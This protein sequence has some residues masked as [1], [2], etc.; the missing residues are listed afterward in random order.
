MFF[1]CIE[2]VVAISGL[3]LVKLGS[4]EIGTLELGLS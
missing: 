3:E 4:P 1:R 2:V